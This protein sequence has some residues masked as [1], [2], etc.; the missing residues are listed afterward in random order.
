MKHSEIGTCVESGMPCALLEYRGGK[1]ESIKW[2][3]KASGKAEE[4]RQVVHCC[5]MRDGT[6]VKV[7][8]RLAPDADLTAV[9]A[10][11]LAGKPAKKGQKI[12]VTLR[13]WEVDR[14]NITA[15]GDIFPVE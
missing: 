10:T 5:E 15:R 4:A 7:I 6:Q 11:I 3:G 9:N 2:V 1:A 12:L 13:S 14:G 8:E